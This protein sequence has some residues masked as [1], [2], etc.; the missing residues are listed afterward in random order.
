MYVKLEESD[1]AMYSNL[2]F[3]SKFMCVLKAMRLCDMSIYA[4]GS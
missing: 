2:V 3:S 4:G 1:V